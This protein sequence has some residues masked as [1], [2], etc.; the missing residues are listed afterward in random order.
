M[1][2]PHRSK[3]S[4]RCFRAPS[5]KVDQLDDDDYNDDDD[6]EYDD[7]MELVL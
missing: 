1:T 3:T 6:N 4:R 5:P 2:P 7:E